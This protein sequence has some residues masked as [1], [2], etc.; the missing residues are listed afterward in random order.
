MFPRRRLTFTENSQLNDN[1]FSA[2]HYYSAMVRFFQQPRAF[3]D[4]FPDECIN[5]EQNKSENEQ[6]NIAPTVKT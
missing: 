4:A 6:P 5:D 1:G 2:R 3:S